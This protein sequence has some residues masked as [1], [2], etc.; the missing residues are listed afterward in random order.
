MSFGWVALAG[1]LAGFMAGAAARFGR[2]CTMGATEAL[3]V[4]HDGR[5][6]RAWGLALAL[7]IGLVAAGEASGAI[8][9]S[10]SLYRQPRVDVVATLLGGL[11]FG[12]GMTFVGTCSFGLLVRAGGGDLRALVSTTLIGITAFAF[13][14]GLLAPVRDALI[15]HATIDLTP[16]GGA[17][18][19][20]LLTSATNA[21]PAATAKLAAAGACIVLLL[22]FAARDGGLWRRGRLLLAATLVGS[23]VAFGW[24]AT[25]I[26][27][28]RL[29][30]DRVESLTFVAPVGRL[31]LQVMIEP[32]RGVEFGVSSVIGVALGSA[33][34]AL[35][36]T[37]MRMEAFDDGREMRRHLLGA[38]LMGMGGV[39]AKG[40]TIGQGL[41]AGSTL[42]VT[43][44]L[45][46]IGVLLGAK[47][48]L[49]YLLEG[50]LP[51]QFGSA[52]AGGR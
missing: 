14:G 5:G 40:C 3:I 1:L 45:F 49:D 51:W 36:R 17:D 30:L 25:S 39:L 12:V 43:M 46:V 9:L 47:L 23:S 26:A 16:H 32:M 18:F 33:A 48:A 31:L 24:L 22:I 20:G 44:P 7:A 21:V 2:L 28:E 41:S 4:S 37:E 38:M 52:R 42:A 27:V 13:T 34:V 29:D 8:D 15:G 6:M 10:T 50:R 35:A 19:G 11:T